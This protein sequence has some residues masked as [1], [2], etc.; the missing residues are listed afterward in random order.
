M[1]EDSTASSASGNSTR[2]ASTMSGTAGSP[3]RAAASSLPDL[4]A[5]GSSDRTRTS[6]MPHIDASEPPSTPP[7][8]LEEVQVKASPAPQRDLHQKK[9]RRSS[10]IPPM[11]FNN[12]DDFSSSPYSEESVQS[13]ETSNTFRTA[14]DEVDSSDSDDKDLVEDETVNH[15]DEDENTGHSI[16]NSSTGSSARL[17]AALRQAAQQAGTQ[18]IT[19]DENDDLSMEMAEDTVTATFIPLSQQENGR[20]SVGPD[21]IAQIDQ[22]NLNPFSPAFKASVRVHE[23]EADQ[24]DTMDFTQAVGKILPQQKQSRSPN[25]SR[26]KSVAGGR[27]KS[28]HSRLGSPGANSE[29]G[30]ETMDFTTAVGAIQGGQVFPKQQGANFE[31]GSDE[32][33]DEITMEFTGV[34]GGVLDPG[35]KPQTTV[36]GFT[37]DQL[38][39]QQLLGESSRRQSGV[40]TMDD[41]DMDMTTVD[42]KIL[43]P[44]RGKTK[45][46]E[47]DMTSMSMTQALG[48]II[49][50]QPKLYTPTEARAMMEQ[51]VETSQAPMPSKSPTKSV[52]KR[53]GS[54][55]TTGEVMTATSDTGSPSL[56]N[57]QT[58][59]N[60]NRNARSGR[61]TTPQQSSRHTT[62]INKT[63]TPS[64]QLTPKEI[65]PETPS[66]TPP[67]KNVSMRG[68]S[69]KKLLFEAEVR[70]E[71]SPAKHSARKSS[72]PIFGANMANGAFTPSVVL[73][74][75]RRRSSGIGADKE[76]LGSPNVAAMLDRRS[77]I[78]E[79]SAT[80]QP[81]GRSGASVR[82]E[83]PR[84]MEREV[85]AEAAQLHHTESGRGIL[86]QEADDQDMEQERDVTADLKDMIQSM[87]PQKKNL[88]GRKSLHV[89]AAK[90]L[91]GKRPAELDESDED[92][93]P[94]RLKGRQA[95]PVKSIKLPA[96]PSKVETTGR[97]SASVR[98]SLKE[99]TGNAQAHT[100]TTHGSPT[101]GQIITT[102]N[103]QSR[104]KDIRDARSP[105]KF[106]ASLG[107]PKPGGDVA[108]PTDDEERIQLQDFLNMTSIRFMELTTTKR[109]HTMAPNDN[110]GR[111]SESG[112]A[113][114]QGAFGLENCVVAGACTVPMLELYQHSCRELKKY[115]NEGRSVVKEIEADT[116]EENPPLFREYITA[117]P[118]VKS[119]MDVQFKNVKTHARLLSKAMWYEWRMKLLDGL[120]EGLVKMGQG[121][122]SDTQNID[123]QDA[124]I[125]PALESLTHEHERLEDQVQLAQKRVDELASCDQDELKEARDCLIAVED[126]VNAKQQLLQELQSELNNKEQRL[127]LASETK[128]EYRAQSQE[129]DRVLEECRGW[130]VSEVKRL[131][132]DHLFYLGA[133]PL[134][135]SNQTPSPC[136]NTRMAGAL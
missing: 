4:G 5:V 134:L 12:P 69:P 19:Y 31:T 54:R 33:D 86:E 80:F 42:G 104:F 88:K 128:E 45:S 119:L 55:R 130:D 109:R 32:E 126:E 111:M 113:N 71:N 108:E 48:S 58:K 102:P 61:S 37:D 91:L 6:P 103:D 10:G 95:S 82:F 123:E 7:E 29:L 90:G 121:M 125:Q 97:K 132:G 30:E 3:Y 65:H 107:Q 114:E 53:P 96:P 117:T 40:S 81:L 99:T 84:V 34:I 47:D 26:R 2:R 24:D 87:T 63:S 11:N 46:P 28:V 112:V 41:D 89:G 36:N 21:P 68:G 35:S 9:R 23:T 98:L 59:N 73:K 22:E 43:E 92:G 8:H 56:V 133:N 105:P 44:F 67:L 50:P 70:Q 74:P 100:P 60:T 15:V 118:D 83:D 17:E 106:Q 1:P 64:K 78:G 62:P 25:R 110:T 79:S 14:E 49:L 72:R 51:E 38:A 131:Q 76:G 18:G 135:T 66:K 122:E 27:R 136:L 57:V 13:D 39:Q 52:S 124:L 120:K 93:T 115:I 94:K 85:D 127:E 16:G 116:L 101:K 20:T 77:S 75:H 129:A